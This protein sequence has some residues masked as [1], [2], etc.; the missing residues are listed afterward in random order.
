MDA[1]KSSPPNRRGKSRSRRAVVTKARD[2]VNHIFEFIDNGA[3][4]SPPI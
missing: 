2:P 3:A 4:S 1:E